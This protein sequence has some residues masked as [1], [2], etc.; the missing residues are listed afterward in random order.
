MNKCAKK[1]IKKLNKIEISHTVTEREGYTAIRIHGDDNSTDNGIDILFYDSCDSV[2]I[3]SIIA[4][5]TEEKLPFAYD[6]CNEINRNNVMFKYY[7]SNLQIYFE[8]TLLVNPRNCVSLT[9]TLLEYAI[10]EVNQ[11]ADDD[12]E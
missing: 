11:Y 10:D 8:H 5:M 3:M 6:F 7:V 12:S 1:F 9:S 2:T 4:E